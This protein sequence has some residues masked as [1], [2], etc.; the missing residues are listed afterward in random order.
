MPQKRLPLTVLSF[1]AALSLSIP[2]TAENE[3]ALSRDTTDVRLSDEPVQW[4]EETVTVVGSD[5]LGAMYRMDIESLEGIAPSLIVDRN[6][7]TPRGA[8]IAI[9]GIYSNDAEK[10]IEPAIATYVDGVYQANHTGALQSL[11]DVERVEIMRGPAP[12]QLPAP[13][14]GGAVM[15]TR[16]RPTGELDLDLTLTPHH[17]SVVKSVRS[18]TCPHWRD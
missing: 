4:T 2:A 6:F 16:S 10:G 11:F 17:S 7:R 5:A 8:N 14:L 18:S 1:F 13:N 9:R 3:Y 12:L 15:Y